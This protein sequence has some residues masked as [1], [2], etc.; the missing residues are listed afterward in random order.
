MTDKPYYYEALNRVLQHIDANL[1]SDLKLQQLAQL[2]HFSPFHFQRIFKSIVGEN[3]YEYILNR[4]LEQAIFMLKHRPKLSITAIAYDCGFPSP[5]N[6][7]R[8]FKAR[9]GFTAST[10]RRDKN[11]Q[12]SKIYQEDNPKS[13]YLVYQESRRA[14]SPKFEV[15]ISE[16]KAI[17]IA[18]IRATFGA[19]GSAL[20]EA[21]HELMNWAES[22]K[23]PMTKIRR[24]GMSM[25][26]PEVTPSQR[27]RYD[28]AVANPEGK[29]VS[30]RVEEGEIRGGL[31]VSL[32]CIGDLQRVAQAWDFLYRIWLPESGY[33]PR[34]C[35]AIEAFL[36]GPE[37]IGWDQFDMRCSV[38]IQKL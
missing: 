16:E 35:P 6:F 30:G 25:D 8:Q 18:L 12:K 15:T 10:F 20:L 22:A 11:L 34:H 7:S 24:Y 3:P 17:P 4:R 37:E 28:F 27:Y 2:S 26:D 33:V 32:R 23:I 9:Y 1:S 5:E 19:D 38:P 13:F 31:Y 29:Q 14:E 36:K 21:Y